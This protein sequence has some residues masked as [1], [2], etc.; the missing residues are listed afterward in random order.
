L[1]HLASRR[2]ELLEVLLGGC[3]AEEDA[4]AA[5]DGAPDAC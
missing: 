3:V 5:L 2:R 1:L 4:D